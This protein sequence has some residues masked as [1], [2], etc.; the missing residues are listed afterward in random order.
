MFSPALHR[1]SQTKQHLA[2]GP[3]LEPES[4]NGNLSLVHGPLDPPLEDFTLGSLLDEQVFLRGEKECLVVAHSRTR[5][6]YAELQSRSRR[7]AKGLLALGLEKGDRVG[8]LASNCAEFVALFFAVGYLG[9]ILVVLNATYTE[10]EARHALVHSGCKIVFVEENYGRHSNSGLLRTLREHASQ[11]RDVKKVVVLHGEPTA[12]SAYSDIEDTFSQDVSD[13]QLEHAMREVQTHDVCNL[14]YTSGSTG[15]PKAA[16]LSHHNLINNARFIGQ[17]MS[18][19]P[20]DTLCCP[21]PLFHCFGLVLGLLTC[22]THGSTIIIPSPT[23][24]AP[25]VLRVLGTENCTALHGVPAMFE[26]LLSL[27]FPPDFSCPGLRTGIIAGAP[28]PKPLMERLFRELGMTEF[29]SSYGLTE[30]SPTCFN[31]TTTTSIERRLHSVGKVMPHMHAKIVNQA[32][33]IVKVGER[34]ELCMA[35]YSLQKGYWMSEAKTRECMIPDETGVVWLHT[36]DEAVF[37]KEGYCAI[38]GRF[39]DIIIRGGENIYPLE[40]ETRIST[41]PSGHIAQAVVVGLPHPKYGEVVA[42]FLLPSAISSWLYRPT[43]EEIRGWVRRALGWHKA[44]EHVFWF[45]DDGVPGEVPLTGSGKVKK[46]LL[47]DVGRRLLERERRER[48]EWEGRL[49]SEDVSAFT[50]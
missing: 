1:L 18:F 13:K 23:F 30:A 28:V 26:E 24:S 48:A 7:L 40:I 3:A 21:P 35:G 46:H 19:T 20:S 37:D 11:I 38:T 33:Q 44:P 6:T 10:G 29:T 4:S 31:A 5:W 32:G 41:H 2:P 42:A 36:G 15:H 50:I 12:F 9:G 47:R 8:I 22:I 14:Q 34:G 17:R 39:K 25:S 27:T 43:D 45:G 16:M 49:A